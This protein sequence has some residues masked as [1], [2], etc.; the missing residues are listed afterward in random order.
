M[1]ADAIHGGAPPLKKMD[2]KK[3]RRMPGFFVM[4]ERSVARRSLP[5]SAIAEGGIEI[6]FRVLK[7]RGT[8]WVAQIDMVRL[9]V[10][11]ARRHSARIQFAHGADLQATHDDIEPFERHS[12][13]PSGDLPQGF[14]PA[15]RTRRAESE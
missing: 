4:D 15:G 9:G 6:D 12:R 14:S 2:K 10:R 11:L 3:A 5:T 7:L 13:T 8:V 1:R